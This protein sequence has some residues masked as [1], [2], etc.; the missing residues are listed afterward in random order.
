[1]VNGVFDFL[2]N[3]GIE[4]ALSKKR[5]PVTQSFDNGNSQVCGL[6]GVATYG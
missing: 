6:N 3:S 5:D 2:S 4:N 1:M